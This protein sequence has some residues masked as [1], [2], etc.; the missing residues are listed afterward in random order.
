MRSPLYRAIDHPLSLVPAG[1]VRGHE[2]SKCFR[3]TGRAKADLSYTECDPSLF[4]ESPSN[5]SLAK[6]ARTNPDSSEIIARCDI[7]R[8]SSST[9]QNT[10][11]PGGERGS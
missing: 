1:L 8:I 2:H 7:C 4:S 3:V 5:T 11:A 9:N 10:A 6:L